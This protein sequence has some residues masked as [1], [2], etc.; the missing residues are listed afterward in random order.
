MTK[1]KLDRPTNNAYLFGVFTD[2]ELSLAEY[3]RAR[4]A[5]VA[6]VSDAEHTA[7]SFCEPVY[8]ELSAPCEITVEVKNEAERQD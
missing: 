2:R 7:T 5:A 4:Q 1:I 3:E 8:V 6:A